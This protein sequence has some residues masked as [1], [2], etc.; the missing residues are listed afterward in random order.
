MYH[1]FRLLFSAIILRDV[2]LYFASHFVGNSVGA[3]SVND[4]NISRPLVDEH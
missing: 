2:T 1:F 4:P 3:T